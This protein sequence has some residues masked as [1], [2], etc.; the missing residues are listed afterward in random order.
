[1]SFIR[2]ACHYG[3]QEKGTQTVEKRSEHMKNG[4]EGPKR[5]KTLFWVVLATFYCYFRAKFKKIL[6]SEISI[7]GVLL[8]NTAGRDVEQLVG[9]CS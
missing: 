8:I 3:F 4:Q 2:L 6:K 5:S 9:H 7:L 1:M